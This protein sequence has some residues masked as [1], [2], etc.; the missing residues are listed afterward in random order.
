MASRSVPRMPRR[1]NPDPGLRCPASVAWLC[2]TEQVS[3]RF[4]SVGGGA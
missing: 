1:S 4:F 3:G 2:G